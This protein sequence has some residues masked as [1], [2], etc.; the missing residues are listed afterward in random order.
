MSLGNNTK[1]GLC[2]CRKSLEKLCYFEIDYE[3]VDWENIINNSVELGY[4][5]DK[6][7]D[8]SSFAVSTGIQ[9]TITTGL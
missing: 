1:H 8:G 9:T 5:V 6:M 3:G 7:A 2:N 4:L